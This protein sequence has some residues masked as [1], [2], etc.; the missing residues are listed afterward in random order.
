MI[1]RL[2]KSCVAFLITIL[3]VGCDDVLQPDVLLNVYRESELGCVKEIGEMKLE[4]RYLPNM[5]VVANK[6]KQLKDPLHKNIVWKDKWKESY[7]LEEISYVQVIYKGSS[8]RAFNPENISIN[9]D[10]DTYHASGIL[11][12]QIEKKQ[13]FYEYMLLFQIGATE[14]IKNHAFEITSGQ[15]SCRMIMSEELVEI[16]EAIRNEIK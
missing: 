13:N 10:G 3:V 7:V 14:L 2:Q 5:V 12:V 16:I 4:L 8:E 9:I 1:P 6:L 11:P 15:I